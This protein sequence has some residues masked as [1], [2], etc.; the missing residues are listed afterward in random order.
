MVIQLSPSKT[1]VG[2]CSCVK[3]YLQFVEKKDGTLREILVSCNKQTR[4]GSCLFVWFNTFQNLL[5]WGIKNGGDIS[6][7]VKILK[8]HACE[9][10]HLT[11]GKKVLSCT[12]CLA[13]IISDYQ[14]FTRKE[15]VDEK[16]KK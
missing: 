6:E 5:N 11:Q 13:G 14:N 4:S 10:P 7:A 9:K 16:E 15:N 8:D 3:F 12:D 2:E 1:L